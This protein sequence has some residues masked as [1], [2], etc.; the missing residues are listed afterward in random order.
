MTKF[1]PTALLI[2]GVVFISGLPAISQSSSE[3][4][5]MRFHD[6]REPSNT[7]ALQSVVWPDVIREANDYATRELKR[8]LNGKNAWVT[9]L[10]ASFKQ[11]EKTYLV[12][13]VL[14]RAC[15]SGANNAGSGVERSIC[16]LR[17]VLFEKGASKT[18]YS[19]TGCYVD[20]PDW[21]MPVTNQH[22][23]IQAR[24]DAATG[25]ITLRALIGGAW[26]PEC[27]QNIKLP[28]K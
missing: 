3:W 5:V 19:G 4:Q 24:F 14:S 15:E 25:A 1:I 20:P 7:D 2:L 9:A 6:L 17:I 22:D 11:G 18:V 23:S 26:V 10:S 28:G 27:T 16:P 8:P 13:T 21:A 12:S